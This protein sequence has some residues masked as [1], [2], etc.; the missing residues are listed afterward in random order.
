MDLLLEYHYHMSIV[1]WYTL[2]LNGPRGHYYP[3]AGHE[4]VIILDDP[5][6][7]L[8]L[9]DLLDNHPSTRLS[10][11]VRGGISQLR[12]SPYTSVIEEKPEIF[13][14]F[15]RIEPRPFGL[16]AYIIYH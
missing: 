10:K 13:L 2:C 16:Q 15:T 4:I 11:P 5:G 1:A 14:L 7:Q 6:V 8:A 12:K 3:S 9:L